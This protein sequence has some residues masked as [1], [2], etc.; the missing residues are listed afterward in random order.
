[1]EPVRHIKTKSRPWKDD[2]GIPGFQEKML[3]FDE[4]DE[5]VVRL[6]YLPPGWGADVF[7]GQPDRHYHTTVIE[8]GFHLFGDF[9]HWEFSSVGDLEGDLKVLEKGTF[10][11]R[12]VRTIHGI[13]P[14][15]VSQ[16]GAMILYW[17]TGSGVSIQD[18]KYPQE[19]VTVPFDPEA[20]VPVEEFATC[21]FTQ[22]DD[23]PW[24]P[25]PTL[26]GWKIKMLAEPLGSDG[27]V[28]IVHVPT[29]WQP[30]ES[31]VLAGTEKRQWLFALAGD[32][33]VTASDGKG[34]QQAIQLGEWD[35]LHW[36]S[37][38]SLQFDAEPV[39]QAGFT[40]LYVGF[41]SLTGN[42]VSSS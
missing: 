34:T 38:G 23:L 12:P 20:T 29:D 27:R 31:L 4:D 32:L 7:N 11:N 41:G 8:R 18:P 22:T 10:M 2:P 9:P 35:Y 28:A 17:N 19:T 37:P 33:S 1:M 42:G 26:S 13:L 21:G 30:D 16:T 6:W 5:S 24:E 39:S 25:H 40:A 36:Q 15:P 14:S 3:C